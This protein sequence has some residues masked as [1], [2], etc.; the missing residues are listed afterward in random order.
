MHTYINTYYILVY[1]Y[2]EIDINTNT[3]VYIYIY[4]CISCFEQMVCIYHLS[5]CFYTLGLLRKGV[6]VLS[7][8]FWALGELPKIRRP[9]YRP[10]II[11]LLLQGHPPKGPLVDRDGFMFLV[12]PNGVE[13]GG[14]RGR[15]A[16][17]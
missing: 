7:T 16:I 13:P 17:I 14:L 8:G 6:G 3:Y 5:C 4:M 12:C 2:N 1:I 11:G 9:Y 15:G 10:Q